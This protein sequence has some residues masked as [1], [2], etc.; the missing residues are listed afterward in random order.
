MFT[1]FA[2]AAALLFSTAIGIQHGSFEGSVVRI[3]GD[4]ILATNAVAVTDDDLRCTLVGKISSLLNGDDPT[5]TGA[6]GSRAEEWVAVMLQGLKETNGACI[7]APQIGISKRIIVMSVPLERI[8]GETGGIVMPPTVLVNPEL[9]P[10][11]DSGIDGMQE[12]WESCLSVPNELV[13]VKRHKRIRYRGQR[14]DGTYV[15]G[16]AWGRLA[17]TLQHEVDHLNGVLMT[18][19]AVAEPSSTNHIRADAKGGVESTEHWD[20]MGSEDYNIRT[21]MFPGASTAPGPG[22]T[23]VYA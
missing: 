23:G 15:V 16:E 3:Q 11:A 7:A 17:L 12:T 5:T 22:D 20:L 19:M 4:P 21:F 18:D 14:L 6:C 8:R 1:R 9:F 13:V 2:L 10:S